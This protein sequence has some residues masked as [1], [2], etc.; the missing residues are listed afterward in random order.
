MRSRFRH[1]HQTRAR[2]ARDVT[3]RRPLGMSFLIAVLWF[4]STFDVQTR[5][6]AGD[7]LPG[8]GPVLDLD[9]LPARHDRVISDE[10]AGVGRDDPHA[11]SRSAPRSTR[12]SPAGGSAGG[13][14]RSSVSAPRSPSR[15][16]SE[17]RPTGRR[18][19]TRWRSRPNRPWRDP[20]TATTSSPLRAR[21]S[22]SGCSSSPSRS[23]WPGRRRRRSDGKRPTRGLRVRD[24]ARPRRRARLAARHRRARRM[25]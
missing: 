25:N 19:G 14:S 22:S 13:R 21:S 15:D 1:A 17:R 4:D 7:V 12:A 2:E 8:G 3:L 18:G 6:H 5:G 16:R 9:V 23:S 10:P 20:S 24:R 11:S